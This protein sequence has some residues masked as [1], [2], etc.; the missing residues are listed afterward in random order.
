M[1]CSST[2]YLAQRGPTVGTFNQNKRLASRH[3]ITIDWQK[4]Q[5]R[6]LEEEKEDNQ[7]RCSACSTEL[8]GQTG[9]E[10]EP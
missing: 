5:E 2:M 6:L 4:W 7:C 9:P 1:S 3:T 8:H 10:T